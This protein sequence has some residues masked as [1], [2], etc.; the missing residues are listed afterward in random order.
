MHH[1]KA[2]SVLPIPRTTLSSIKFHQQASGKFNAN[3]WMLQQGWFANANAQSKPLHEY[4]SED[5]PSGSQNSQP[6]NVD[7]A[8][9]FT[10]ESEP[11]PVKPSD[12]DS[13][14]DNPE[15]TKHQSPNE[16][17]RLLNIPEQNPVIADQQLPSEQSSSNILQKI[18]EQPVSAD[19][20]QSSEQS[21][22]NIPEKVLE[23]QNTTPFITP[24]PSVESISHKEIIIVDDNAG[25]YLF[26]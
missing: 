11:F 6:A 26:S 23:L 24:I 13:P 2:N 12:S 22:S 16:Q 21:S 1:L 4:S 9:L 7:H 10:G 3:Q 20:H 14:E 5:E 18:P 19:Q 17:S 15:Q 25:E 8:L